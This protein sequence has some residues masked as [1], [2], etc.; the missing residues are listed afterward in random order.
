LSL[1]LAAPVAAAPRIALAPVRGER[2][3]RVDAQLQ[4][5]LCPPGRCLRGLLG[6]SRP[7]LSRARRAGADGSLLGSLWRERGGRVLSLAL[8]TTGPRPA[9]TWV[10]PLGPDG[11]IPP[12]E[13]SALARE[14]DETLG[15]PPSFEAAGPRPLVREPLATAIATPIATPTAAAPRR[16]PPGSPFALELGIES[17]R[18][19]LRFPEGGTAPVG[20][21]VVLP[22]APRLTLEFHPLRI[23]GDR[24]AGLALF[25][26][27]SWLPGIALPSGART[28]EATS[29][30]LR[31]GIRW[32]LPVV[33]RLLLVP[34]LAWERES[35]VVAPV[36]GT[37]VPGL[38]DDRRA[39]LSAALGAEVPLVGPPGTPRL[40][41]LALG[42]VARWFDAADLAG[43]ADFFPGGSAWTVEGEAGAAL[44]LAPALSVRLVA[45]LGSTRWALDADPS[46][47]YTVGSARAD[48]LGARLS[49][50]LEP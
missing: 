15:V 5:A 50:R 37:K 43:G 18:R 40:S 6:A 38:P 46:G 26:E 28:H 22:A 34:A 4:G 45:T 8:F 3:D 35:F 14:L 7:D 20:Y 16:G 27:G 25:A 29:L 2:G 17:M 48:S 24:A 1:A 49:V 30:A 13:L 19:T 9:R 42:R 11:L 21:E 47:A 33:E 36:D 12:E 41:A 23:A 10:V 39:G 32:R 44:R 31:A